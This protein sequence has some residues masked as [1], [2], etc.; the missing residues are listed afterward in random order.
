MISFLLK[1]LS[2]DQEKS[3][4]E[5]LGKCKVTENDPAILFDWNF[6]VLQQFVDGANQN[7]VLP[8]AFFI[9]TAPGNMTVTSLLNDIMLVLGRVSGGRNGNNL[10]AP[11]T[12]GQ[13]LNIRSLLRDIET[14]AWFQQQF[15]QFIPVG[16]FLATVSQIVDRRIANATPSGLVPPHG[17]RQ[18]FQ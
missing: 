9:T 15:A 13:A 3:N 11:N 18:V 7:V 5:Y 12:L 1:M 4:E 6:E 10:L 8:Q 16:S 17:F 14:N 2:V